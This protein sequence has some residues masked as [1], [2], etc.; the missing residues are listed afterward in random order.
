MLG[1]Y[2]AVVNTHMARWM[3][4]VY[5]FIVLLIAGF[6]RAEGLIDKT[7]FELTPVLCDSNLAICK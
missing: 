5:V 7:S 1:I 6:A 4:F 3:I 2:F